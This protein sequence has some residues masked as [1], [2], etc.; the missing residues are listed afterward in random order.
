MK[1]EEGNHC[2]ILICPSGFK[3]SLESHDAADHIEAGIFRILPSAHIVKAPLV[4]S[5]KGFTEGLV[6]ATG[7]QLVACKVTVPVGNAV[8]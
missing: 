1:F 5:D 4:D 3:E 8:P 2:R 7:G 6:A